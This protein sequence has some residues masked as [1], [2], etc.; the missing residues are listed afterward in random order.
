M[1]NSEKEVSELCVSCGMCCDGTLFARGF[2][3]DEADRKVADDCG[4]VTLK[5][6]ETLF[7]NLPCH[8]FSTC[9]TIYDKPRPHTCSVY[10]CPPIKRHKS[11]EQSF[12]DTEQQVQTLQQQRDK[13]L[14]IASEFPELSQLNFRELKAKLEEWAGD[15]EKV[16]LYKHLFLILFIFDDVRKRYFT[17]TEKDKLVI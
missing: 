11:G 8:H 9:C 3:R 7:F 2:V 4:M 12:E 1:S 15:E 5:I 13:L 16:A 10:F 6:K 17:P 14:K